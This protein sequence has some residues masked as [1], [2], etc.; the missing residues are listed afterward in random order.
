MSVEE[1]KRL[2]SDIRS[3][4]ALAEEFKGVSDVDALVATAKEKGYDIS[5]SDLKVASTK[6]ELSDDDLDAAAGGGGVN[7]VGGMLAGLVHI[8]GGVKW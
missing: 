6:A 2:D 8:H 7:L 3:N 1:V 4:A 5:A